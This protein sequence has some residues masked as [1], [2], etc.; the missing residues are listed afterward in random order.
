MYC[1][2]IAASPA[3]VFLLTYKESILLKNHSIHQMISMH[4]IETNQ[5]ILNFFLDTQ[6]Y[7]T[8][9]FAP[10]ITDVPIIS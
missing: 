8:N 2:A 9:T 3:F 10:I 1:F 6:A 7:S 5:T 4:L